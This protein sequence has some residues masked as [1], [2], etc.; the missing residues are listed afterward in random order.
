M[1]ATPS[2]PRSKRMPIPRNMRNIKWLTLREIHSSYLKGEALIR[3]GWP[4]GYFLEKWKKV[5]S[6][7]QLKYARSGKT[8]GD[9]FEYQIYS[10]GIQT[11]LRETKAEVVNLIVEDVESGRL[12]LVGRTHP[13]AEEEIIAT[14]NW[15][16]M[17]LDIEK[18]VASDVR[19]DINLTFRGIRGVF[20]RRI[21]A[22]DP[23]VERIRIAERP[24]AT[25]SA[26]AEARITVAPALPAPDPDQI[27]DEEA[28]RPSLATEI[29]PPASTKKPKRAKGS[30][31]LNLH[32]ADLLNLDIADLKRL[33]RRKPVPKNASVARALIKCF[34]KTNPTETPLSHKRLANWLG[35][36]EGLRVLNQRYGLPE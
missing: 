6:D 18:G 12:V 24:L 21:P 7:E 29:E 33:L 36:P 11:L 31:R 4:V 30:R 28:D 25:P 1:W 15:A 2:M 16:F 13:D 22:R 3:D 34:E 14:R 32:I 26:Y 20:R 8:R 19:K 9:R 17:D 10:G 27:R 23:I 35:S 5:L